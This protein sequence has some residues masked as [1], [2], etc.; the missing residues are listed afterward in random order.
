MVVVAGITV[1]LLFA[2][3]LPAVL[4]LA[5]DV[6]G[7]L[8]VGLIPSVSIPGIGNLRDLAQSGLN[9]ILRVEWHIL[10]AELEPLVRLFKG[11]VGA[12]NWFFDGVYNV[13]HMLYILAVFLFGTVLPGLVRWADNANKAVAQYARDGLSYV[14]N[15]LAHLV[16]YAWNQT[17]ALVERVQA[18]IV[19]H[20]AAQLADLANRVS[21]TFSYYYHWNLSALAA[22]KAY[23]DGT[24][25]AVLRYVDSRI[26]AVLG[27]VQAALTSLAAQVG[28][29]FAQAT[30]HANQVALEAER[31]AVD[32]VAHQ[33]RT[34]AT[35]GWDPMAES[36]H[37]TAVEAGTDFGAGVEGLAAVPD[38]APADVGLAVGGLSVAVHALLDLSRQCTIPNCRNLSKMGR[39]WQALT[40]LMAA[41][42]IFD[43]VADAVADPEGTARDV[44]ETAGPMVRGFGHLVAT[45]VGA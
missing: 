15:T 7:T 28:Q 5:T 17:V 6:F 25:A 20:V 8:I 45:E 16:A 2:A 43:L 1:D 24:V 44:A 36:A 40:G 23:V 3:L 26:G 22:L 42:A 33:V 32:F 27:Y 35:P 30:E 11:L 31:G 38:L 41:G 14:Q 37:A 39:D 34:G 29:L 9:A 4:V 18:A 21:A 12:I 19:A 10:D 13:A